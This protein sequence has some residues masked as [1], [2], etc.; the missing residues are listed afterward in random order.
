[1]PKRAVVTV[2]DKVRAARKKKGLSQL[3]LAAEAGVRPEV[4]SRIETGKSAGSLASLHKIA[5]LLD[6]T[7][8]DLAPRPVAAKTSKAL[9]KAPSKKTKKGNP[10]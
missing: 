6:L 5:P 10:T 7:L 8:D 1:M 4:V 2:A 3:E 9:D